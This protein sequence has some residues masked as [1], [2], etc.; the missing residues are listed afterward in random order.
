MKTIEIVEHTG[1]YTEEEKRINGKTVIVQVARSYTCA[2]DEEQ[3]LLARARQT[4]ELLA[5]E[6]G[7]NYEARIAS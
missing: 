3:D 6:E 4:A 5:R 7:K 2:D 1:Q